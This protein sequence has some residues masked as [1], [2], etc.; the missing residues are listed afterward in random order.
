MLNTPQTD[1]PTPP[2]AETEHDSV[3]FGGVHILTVKEGARRLSIG[4]SSL[5]RLIGSGEFPAPKKLTPTG[6][7][8]GYLSEDFDQYVRDYVDSLQDA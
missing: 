1:T 6:T 5:Y 3:R 8:V 7:R 4:S 2:P